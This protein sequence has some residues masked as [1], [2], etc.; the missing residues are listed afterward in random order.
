MDERQAEAEQRYISGDITLR[1]LA[2]ETGIPLSTLSRWSRARGWTKKR[3]RFQ[4]RA[5]KKAVTKATDKKARAL[6]Q[7]MDASGEIETALLLMA[8]GVRAL[9]DG[10]E[11]LRDQLENGR[12]SHL[13]SLVDALGRQTETR[14][15]LSGIL[16]EADKEK[17]ALLR[18]RQELDE[19][20]EQEDH[21]TSAEVRLI[22][23]PDLEGLY[24]GDDRDTHADAESQAEAVPGQP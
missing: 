16:S 15:L 14:M 10:D 8:R 19:K 6:A 13:K 23:D 18:R 22:L 1:A 3:E 20:R 11:A 7:L 17:L 12:A 24:S 21:A 4:A 9:L 2:E 5:M